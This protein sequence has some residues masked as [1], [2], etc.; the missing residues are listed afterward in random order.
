MVKLCLWFCLIAVPTASVW[1][2][3]NCASGVQI[4]IDQ[5]SSQSSF[6]NFATEYQRALCKRL[7]QTQNGLTQGGSIISVV[8]TPEG[9]VAITVIKMELRRIGGR[10]LTIIEN[11]EWFVNPA[12]GV[13]TP[14]NLT[15]RFITTTTFIPPGLSPPATNKAGR[16]S[17]PQNRRSN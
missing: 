15:L 11:K 13:S 14:V 9:S 12:L 4:L 8:F 6:R 1:G 16:D 10:I 5:E 3:G 7:A 17:R 2:A